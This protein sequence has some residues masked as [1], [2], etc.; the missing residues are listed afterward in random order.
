MPKQVRITLC[1]EA[2][3]D[4]NIIRKTA[5]NVSK[6]DPS[7]IRNIRIVKRSVD[8]RQKNIKVILTVD[9]FVEGEPS[10]TSFHPFRSVN[11]SQAKG[12]IIVGAGPAGLFAALK[13]I[14]LGI[15]PVIIE[16]GKDISTRKKDI[17]RISREQVID[18]DSNYCFG[19]GGAGTFSDGKL[20][21]RSKKRGDNSRV[22]ELLCLHGANENILYE[23]HP[24]LGTDK[25]PRIITGIR[26]TITDAGGIFL[27]E[28]KIT[29][30]LVEGKQVKRSRCSRQRK[31]PFIL[32]HSGNRPF[33]KG[34]L[35][36]LLFEEHKS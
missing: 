14:E 15:R 21:T 36:Y 3:A 28:K 17:A 27:F 1:P 33:G 9:I 6:T 35:P 4:N 32:C 20:Y 34:H 18:P 16:R 11:V 2:A 23:A 22:L 5:A 19:E 10:F 29:D 25:L 7:V 8:A 31:V 26:K 24:H 12:V 30:I 13:L